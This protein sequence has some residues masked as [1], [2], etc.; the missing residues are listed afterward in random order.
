MRKNTKNILILNE[1]M[2]DNLG[3]QAIAAS[4][5]QFVNDKGYFSYSTYIS[6]PLKTEL[7]TQDYKFKDIKPKRSSKFNA[8]K[9]YLYIIVFG[10][11]YKKIIIERLTS[12][13]PLKIIIGGG[14][15]LN[16]SKNGQVNGFS[17]YLYWW[18]YWIKKIKPNVPISIIGVGVSNGHNF[19]EKHLYNKALSKINKIYVRDNLSKEVLIK[20]YKIE[21]TVIP[22]IAFYTSKSSS[23][24]VEKGNQILLGIANYKEVYLTYN[25]HISIEMY[26]EYILDCSGFRDKLV[27]VNLFYTT[28]RDV[29]ECISFQSYILN[30]YGVSLNII[31]V[32]TLNDLIYEIKKSKTICSGRMHAL[33][34][35]L[36]YNCQVITFPIS[37][38]LKTFDKENVQSNQYQNLMNR[39]LDINL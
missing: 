31:Q 9:S 17:I 1:C 35:G 3:D 13:N 28:K 5:E 34:L 6:N 27:D 4:M 20:D 22:D 29:E 15:L 30:K 11:K 36:K 32:N 23:L 33:I 21:S 18:T 37:E 38:K 7:V 16:A 14:Q 8:L 26:Y 19:I 24:T 25:E 2:S 39:L 12:I 10:L